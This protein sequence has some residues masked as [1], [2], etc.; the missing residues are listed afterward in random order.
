MIVCRSCVSLVWAVGSGAYAKLNLRWYGRWLQSS[1]SQGYPIRIT[2]RAEHWNL[3]RRNGRMTE[4]FRQRILPSRS[5]IIN[6]IFPLTGS[7]DWFVN[8]KR[9][10]QLPVTMPDRARDCLTAEIQNLM[11]RQIPFTA[12]KPTRISWKSGI[13]YLKDPSQEVASQAHAP[14][15]PTIQYE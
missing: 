13:L 12:Q 8:K 7:S 14:S 10:M 11:S 9:P 3:P 2:M 1:A 15:Y 5:L 4:W 6:S